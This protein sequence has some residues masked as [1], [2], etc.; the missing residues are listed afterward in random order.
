MEGTFTNLAGRV[1][2]FTQALRTPGATRPLWL[3]GS[4]VLARLSAGEAFRTAGA[5]FAALAQDFDEF[6]GLSYETLG[7]QGR[8][9]NGVAPDAAARP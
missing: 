7:L 9:V 4:A 3:T 2:R 1:Q 6:A 8:F 5:A